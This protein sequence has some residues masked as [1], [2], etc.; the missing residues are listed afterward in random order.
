[1]EKKNQILS[2]VRSAQTLCGLSAI[3]CGVFTLKSFQWT[4]W[5]STAPTVLGGVLTAFSWDAYRG[6]R[7]VERELNSF[8]YRFCEEIDSQTT[9]DEIMKKGFRSTF[10]WRFASS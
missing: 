6:F 1:M 10:L 9:G 5:A 4:H 2:H 3:V 7:A 8:K